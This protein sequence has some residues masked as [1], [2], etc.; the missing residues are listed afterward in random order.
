VDS[1][2]RYE[3]LKHV[4]TAVR[5]LPP[6]QRDRAIVE[7]CGADA[8]LAD[9]ARA[10]L[11][12][13]TDL[14]ALRTGA[15]GAGTVGL[16]A[17]SATL[18]LQIGAYELA[19]VLGEGGMGV[20]YRAV[21]HAPIRREVA[22]KLIR[23][24]MDTD[25]IVQRFNI[26]RQTLAVM[27]H[28]AIAR[29]F[30]AGAT[31]D[32][33]PYFVMELVDGVPITD[34][35][36]AHGLDLDARLK[37]FLDVL[38][39][40]RHAHQKGI[41]HRD[42]KPGNV[43]VVEQDGAA[44]PKIIDFG[45]AKAV[46]DSAVE[47][48]HGVRGLGTPAYMSPEQ[49]GASPAPVDTRTD[50]YA[51][52]VLLYELLTGAPPFAMSTGTPAE[53]LRVLRDERPSRPSTVS[54]NT[55]GVPRQHL[56]GDLDSVMLKALEHDLERRYESVEAFANDLVRYRQGLPVTARAATWSYRTARFIGRHRAAVAAA[57]LTVAALSGSLAF[58]LMSLQEARRERDAAQEARQVADATT[59]FLANT[60]AAANTSLRRP[61]S[62]DVRVRDVLDGAVE[63]LDSGVVPQPA[64]EVRLRQTLAGT[65][66]ALGAVE[67]SCSQYEQAGKR[68]AEAFGALDT[69]AVIN[70][71][72][73]VNCLGQAS[74]LD[75]AEAALAP[76]VAAC[77]EAP[78]TPQVCEHAYGA[79]GN[80]SFE[81]TRYAQAEAA[82]R[83]AIE[84]AAL[85]PDDNERMTLDMGLARALSE[86]Q[87]YEEAEALYRDLIARRSRV[88]GA[89]H[90][91][92]QFDRNGLG[93]LLQNT[94]RAA[95]AI[96][97]HQ[98]TLDVMTRTVG[99]EHD[100]T[101]RSRHQLADAHC[102]AGD[103]VS[104]R[105]LAAEAL[106]VRQRTLGPEHPQTLRPALTW[107]RAVFDAGDREAGL[108]AIADAVAT[109]RRVLPGDDA[110]LAAYL[111][112]YA[113]RLAQV[114]QWEEALATAE[115]AVAGAERLGPDT[116]TYQRAAAVLA[117][118]FTRLGRAEEAAVWRDRIR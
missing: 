23:R 95:E 117:E 38:A 86:Q 26:E 76:V 16:E 91:L 69:R 3:R 45:I 1:Q 92:T 87:E 96:T 111:V 10:L 118:S 36:S 67:S 29:V 42:L 84:V 77:D 90:M 20:V 25:R 63:R 83:R 8:A 17:E 74:R 37:V 61:G 103:F 55:G 82:F 104:C 112:T 22:I 94:G 21:Q 14:P 33:R 53:V 99:L 27:D 39:G 9:E 31:A 113:E 19:S 85:P 50:V 72:D 88:M 70:L 49:A 93:I 97:L 68:A 44:V 58:A 115:E 5:S 110:N 28:P 79:L 43:L 107:A 81:R 65:Y 75:E 2:A 64:V 30:D 62:A 60:I 108:A 106:E 66:R 57:T 100:L 71:T 4:I 102:D 18:G 52:G 109:A 32:G 15:F 116:P 12:A 6:D 51:L 105:D 73:W 35:A 41:I 34:Y 47:L 54:R 24:G 98:Q 101:L 89:D 48:T 46:G 7:L 56:T 78:V 13:D 59:T 80:I 114:D 40:V 11:A